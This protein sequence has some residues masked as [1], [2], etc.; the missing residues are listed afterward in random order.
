MGNE[1]IP[2]SAAA[3]VVST[4]PEDD[5]ED[6]F[7]RKP[8]NF[9]EAYKQRWG[10][11]GRPEVGKKEEQ[12]E[13]GTKDAEVWE[14]HQVR[15][16]KEVEEEQRQE[17]QRNGFLR[18]YNRRWGNVEYMKDGR[19]VEYM[20]DGSVRV[21]LPPVTWRPK[22]P[23]WTSWKTLSGKREPEGEP[24]MG[25]LSHDYLLEDDDDDYDLLY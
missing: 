23:E 7:P 16:K 17:V 10:G 8:K 13:V 21:H 4:E 15:E 2:G 24:L 5:T 12:T 6:A 18:A 1:G 3:A 22:E 11:N 20:K 25:G 14:K 9:L 19:R